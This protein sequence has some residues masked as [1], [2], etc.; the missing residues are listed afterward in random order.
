MNPDKRGQLLPV[1]EDRLE[2]VRHLLDKQDLPTDDIT[3]KQDCLY[4]YSV[5]TTR[6]GVGGLECFESV[7]LLRSVVIEPAKQG[8]GYGQ[9]LCHQLFEQAATRGVTELYL[10]TTTAESFF[11]NLGFDRIRRED[12]P[13][14]IQQTSEFHDLCPTTATCMRKHLS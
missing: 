5:N 4:V 8:Q 9:L 14:A 6:V 3:T 10:L 13:P 1:T 7:A 12:A 11:A 2:Y